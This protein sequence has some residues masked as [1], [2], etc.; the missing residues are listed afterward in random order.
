MFVL[1]DNSCSWIND[2]NLRQNLKTISKNISCNFLI[3]G[4]G[5]T[6]LSA[7]R[8]LAS[9][10]P[11]ERI[12]IVDSQR[13][14]EGASS[15]NSGYLVDTTLN[16]GF[17]TNKELSTY[18]IKTDIYDLG[19]KF[20]KR[21][22]KNYQVDCDWNE[23]GKFF[24]SSRIIDISTLEKF[25]ESLSKLG[26]NNNLLLNNDLKQLLG[27]EF[28]K[29]G[30]HTTGGILLHPGK[31]ARAMVDVLPE[32]IELYENS[33]LINWKKNK[34]YIICDFANS[35]IKTK[36]II[37]CTNGFFK[38]IGIKKNYN[39]PL[40]LTAS[41]TR[42]LTDEEFKSIGEPKEWGV[43][44][45]RPMGA[46]VRMT[47]DRRILIRNTADLHSPFKMNKNELKKRFVIQKIGIKKR[48]PQLPDDII[49]STWSG[50]V[51]RSGNGSQ[52]FEK[53]DK[54]IYAAGCYNGSGIGVGTL[55]GEQIAIMASNQHSD[56]IDVIN[57]RIK[58]NRLP[59]NPIL[60][61]GVQVRLFYERIRARSEV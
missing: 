43:L 56:E 27:T 55:F 52:I 9:L 32:N 13:A 4:A 57:K 36:K 15:R 22:I 34:D 39:F 3:I 38:S 44:P 31:L 25:S 42:S 10:F 37:F 16:D 23:C 20:V 50:V 40:T 33:T 17:T 26:F 5:I 11:N 12:I 28:Y 14:G 58:P 53:V 1:N 54:N 30:L 24:A 51:S 35:N 8:K 2:L 7:A 47:K 19:I 59:P 49:K 41:M 18:K 60:N 6:G 45:V 48:F 61:L 46:T 29:V 21:F